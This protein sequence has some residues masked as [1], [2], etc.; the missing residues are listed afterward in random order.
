MKKKLILAIMFLC[1]G[2]AGKIAAIEEL[3]SHPKL[4][5][6]HNIHV[7]PKGGRIFTVN[8]QH[9]NFFIPIC[10]EVVIDDYSSDVIKF[11]TKSDNVSY[12]YF[13]HKA[14][15]SPI[16]NS[17]AKEIGS[18]CPNTKSLSKIDQEGIKKAQT[19]VGMTK[20]GVLYAIGNPPAHANNPNIENSDRWLYWK[21]RFDKVAIIFDD[22]GLVKRIQ[23]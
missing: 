13:Y 23:N 9:G 5:T 17:I 19:L 2:C 1:F 15:R 16:S 14:I 4:Y 8:Y 12:R 3:K 20:K 18:S 10:S 6:L 22:N 7:D 11:R 21:N